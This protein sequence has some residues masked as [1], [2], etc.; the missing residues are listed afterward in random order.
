LTEAVA[1]AGAIGRVLVLGGARSGKSTFAEQLLSDRQDVT[2]VAPWSDPADPDW[3]GRVAAH[4]AGRPAGW[5]TLETPDVAKALRAGGCTLVDC[6]TTWLAA[7]MDDAGCWDA[8]PGASDRLGTRIDDLVAAYA[9]STQTV[10][11]SNELGQGVVPAT[12]SGRLFRDEMGRLNQRLAAA[13][14][15]VWFITAGIPTRLR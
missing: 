1:G 8:E 12:A 2:Y 13:S 9:E 3:A 6:V 15:A 10:A 7:A 11:V 4:Q 5:V 14:D